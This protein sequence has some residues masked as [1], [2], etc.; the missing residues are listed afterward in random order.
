MLNPHQ[1]PEPIV[2]EATPSDKYQ[3]FYIRYGAYMVDDYGSREEALS[4]TYYMLE[5]MEGI[6]HAILCPDGSV[7]EK[8]DIDAYQETRWREQ[9]EA[10]QRRAPEPPKPLVY[11]TF[12]GERWRKD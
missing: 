8:A 2:T 9:E 10:R 1:R 6:P 12:R 3:L 7:L 11:R 4:A 5:A